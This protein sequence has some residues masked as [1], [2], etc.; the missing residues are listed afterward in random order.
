[1]PQ[2]Q[3]WT[4]TIEGC[5]RPH[6]TRGY[7]NVHHARFMRG[8]PMCTEIKERNR[9]PPPE[10]TEEGCHGAVVAHGLCNMHYARKLRHGHTN[11]RS[12]QKPRQQCLVDGCTDYHYATG[13]CHRHYTGVRKWAEKGLSRDEY[14]VLQGQ[15]Q[16][17]ICG[18]GEKS[19]DSKSRRRKYMAIDH[20][21]TTGR[22]RGV[23]CSNCNRALGLFKDS[24]DILRRAIAYLERGASDLP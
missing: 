7:C 8:A 1:M 22:V 23:L 17:V 15:R 11:P 16:C 18:E 19:V 21:H 9:N 3:H 20:C 4:C 10:C 6:K 12:R 5:G 14:L 24:P 2:R 13:L